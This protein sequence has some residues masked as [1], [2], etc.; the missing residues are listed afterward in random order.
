[1]QL[2]ALSADGAV[3][4]VGA[5]SE[6]SLSTG[7]G[8]DA[9]N[10]VARE[11]GAAYLFRRSV[12]AWAEEA[13]VKA[14]NTGLGDY[15]GCSVAL[16][17]DGSVLVVGAVSEDSAATRIGGD[18]FNNGAN[19]AGAVYAFRR[20]S[21]GWSQEAYVKAFHAG[22]GDAFG[23][24]VALSADATRLAVGALGDD[25]IGLGVGADATS[26]PITRFRSGAVL[27]Y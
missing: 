7:I 13:Y 6:D 24:S 25:S 15:F 4:A 27:V 12:G 5:P 17:A 8:G 18:E 3:L 21:G 22:A 1:M 11:S 16:S 10:N 19:E 20:A 2:L 14:S 23:H 26:D 9:T